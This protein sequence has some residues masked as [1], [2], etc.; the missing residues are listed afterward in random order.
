MSTELENK[1]NLIYIFVWKKIS[2]DIA[3]KVH[4]ESIE[5]TQMIYKKTKKYSFLKK[6]KLHLITPINCFFTIYSRLGIEVVW[7]KI[8]MYWIRLTKYKCDLQLHIKNFKFSFSI[9]NSHLNL[10]V[11][12]F[13]I[14]K[15]YFVVKIVNEC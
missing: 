11:C 1:F 6:N 12:V 3:L 4:L 15:G 8:R 10:Y 14:N 7:G 5:I 9:Q 13:L 2:K